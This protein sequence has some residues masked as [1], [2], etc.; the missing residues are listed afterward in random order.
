[1][2]PLEERLFIRYD[3]VARSYEVGSLAVIL[4]EEGEVSVARKC[5]ERAMLETA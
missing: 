5:T 3:S 1:M 2:F 4:I